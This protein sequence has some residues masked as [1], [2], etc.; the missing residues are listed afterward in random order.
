M[1]AHH[2]RRSS[3]SSSSSSDDDHYH[4]RYHHGFG[5]SRQAVPFTWNCSHNERISEYE[6]V[7][8]VRE[9]G[10]WGFAGKM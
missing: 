6:F 9:R 5:Y 2:H 7:M 3:S 8:N 10:G 1:Y 4:H